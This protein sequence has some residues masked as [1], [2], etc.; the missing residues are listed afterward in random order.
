MGDEEFEEFQK[1]IAK[2]RKTVRTAI[3][4]LSAAILIGAFADYRSGGVMMA[5]SKAIGS[6]F[7]RVDTLEQLI[8]TEAAK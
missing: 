4:L 1:Q 3:Y 6:L 8:L 7:S 5:Q 2:E